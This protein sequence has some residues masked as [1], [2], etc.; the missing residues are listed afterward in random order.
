MRYTY[1]I[2]IF[3]I[4]NFPIVKWRKRYV[5]IK[6][7]IYNIMIAFIL[8]SLLDSS[9]TEELVICGKKEVNTWRLVIHNMCRLTN[10]LNVTQSFC[11]VSMSCPALISLSLGH[12]FDNL[13]L[14]SPTRIE[15]VCCWLLI[16][17]STSMRFSQKDSNC[18][19]FWFGD[20]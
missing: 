10:H 6:W 7:S 2:C 14:K 20:L 11:K 3:V 8:N 13:A 12:H 15:H 19:W 5:E 1:H 4:P 17:E 9:I 18:S 16:P